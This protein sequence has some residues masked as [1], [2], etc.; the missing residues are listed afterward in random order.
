MLLLFGLSSV[1]RSLVK[2]TTS[3]IWVLLG[4]VVIAFLFKVDKHTTLKLLGV[5]LVGHIPAI[6][7][8]RWAD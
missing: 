2:I 7:W 4:A 8:M 3:A 6:V 5:G 1:F